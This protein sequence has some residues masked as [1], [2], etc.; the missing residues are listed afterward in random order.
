MTVRMRF[1]KHGS[2]S[3]LNFGGVARIKGVV[4]M[5]EPRI[6]VSVKERCGA[7]LVWYQ[8]DSYMRES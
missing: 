1:R 8:T 5:L 7:E 2:Q 4:V 3:R 6:D